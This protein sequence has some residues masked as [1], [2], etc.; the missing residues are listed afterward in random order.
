MND[1]HRPHEYA[2]EL[3]DHGFQDDEELHNDTGSFA[4]LGDDDAEA[5]AKHDDP[6]Y[7]KGKCMESNWK[8][9]YF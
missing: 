8:F 2:D 4:Q 1:E 5:G 3:H 9:L 6:Y 7:R